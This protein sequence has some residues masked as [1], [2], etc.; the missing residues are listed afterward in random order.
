MTSHYLIRLGPKRG[1]RTG[2]LP[3]G[4]GLGFTIRAGAGS[5]EAFLSSCWQPVRKN[6][7]VSSVFLVTNSS[8]QGGEKCL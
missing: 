1:Q 2:P 4:G 8:D 5:C 6:F 3:R 7:L